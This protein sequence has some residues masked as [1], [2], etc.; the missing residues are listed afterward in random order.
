MET[1]AALAAPRPLRVD[2]LV[3]YKPRLMFA[4]DGSPARPHRAGVD[5]PR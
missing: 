2:D 4:G 3:E 1:G 5:S